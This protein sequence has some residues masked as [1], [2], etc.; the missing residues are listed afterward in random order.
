MHVKLSTSKRGSQ[1][2]DLSFYLQLFCHVHQGLT[3]IQHEIRQQQLN[4]R[5]NFGDSSPN[6]HSAL[7]TQISG[8][9]TEQSLDIKQ[10]VK[11]SV[12]TEDEQELFIN[13]TESHRTKPSLGTDV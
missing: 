9:E 13:M 5:T 10:L 6:K 12:L 4:F 8:K 7:V 2:T 11:S 3:L 1:K